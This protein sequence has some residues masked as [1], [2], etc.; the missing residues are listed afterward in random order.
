M[1]FV[2]QK[3]LDQRTAG[4]WLVAIWILSTC[5]GCCCDGAS[6][7]TQAMPSICDHQIRSDHSNF[8]S[9]KSLTVAAEVFAAGAVMANTDADQEI[10]NWYQDDVRSEST[11]DLAVTAKLFGEGYLILPALGISLAA[12]ELLDDQRHASVVGDWADQSLRAMVVGVPPLLVTQ[13][14]TGASRPG[15]SSAESDWVPLHDNNG[16]SGHSFMGAVPFITAAKMSEDPWAKAGFYA[17]STLPGWSRLNDDAH[18]TSQVILG[19]SVA[20]LACSAVSDT[21]QE[22]QDYRFTTVPIPDGVGVGVVFER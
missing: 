22:L 17:A 5:V 9:Q 6:C 1:Q 8:Y 16:V 12:G 19:W 20:Y 3:L 7:A 4:L 14:L 10:Q 15:E 13:S 11:D 18:Y 2:P 21:E